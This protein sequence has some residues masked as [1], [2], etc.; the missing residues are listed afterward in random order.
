ME[1]WQSFL[2]G[3]F[4]LAIFSIVTLADFKKMDTQQKIGLV[5][6]LILASIFFPAMIY[7]LTF[8]N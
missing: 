1:I 7:L 6:W 5:F 4:F 2:L 8:A 3:I